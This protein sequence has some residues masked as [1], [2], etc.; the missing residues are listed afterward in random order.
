[1]V[2]CF[3]FVQFEFTHAIGPHAGSYIV[4]NTGHADEHGAAPRADDLP[5]REALV[6]VTMKPSTADVLAITISGAPAG[7]RGLRRRV[8]EE[9]STEPDAVEVPLLLATF[10]R[11][12]EPFS[13]QDSAARML[14][15]VADS[16]EQQ[17]EWVA[18]G[19]RVVNRAI[20]AYRAGAHD[21]YV[22]EVSR[23]DA[24][25]VRI[26]YGTNEDITAGGWRHAIALP[27]PVGIKA[28]RE[29]RLAPTRTTANVLS[30]RGD[31]LEGEDVLLRAYIDLDHDRVRAA[32][33]QV[34]AAIEL[35]RVELDDEATELEAFATRA[36]A[37]VD[38]VMPDAPA[39]AAG[40]L[41]DLA[42]RVER[43][44]E[45]WRYTAD[46]SD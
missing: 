4:V 9:R 34:R 43:L 7:R 33:L 17:D 24:R 20:R 21:P 40:Q 45:R 30:G 26:G 18:A 16:E 22:T 25:T 2:P 23:R 37:I 6:G 10:V 14:G 11:A 39:D 29:E 46:V 41:A 12:T 42:G 15:G 8:R 3:P 28:R 13:D 27:P 38:A 5:T 1:M 35:L 32:A 31:V 19:L 36:A 44:I